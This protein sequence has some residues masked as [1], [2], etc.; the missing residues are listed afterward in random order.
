MLFSGVVP[1]V[2]RS[3]PS[4]FYRRELFASY[5]II[6][7][8]THLVIHL[9]SLIFCLCLIFI[10]IKL[11][12]SCTLGYGIPFPISFVTLFN[13]VMKLILTL[14]VLGTRSLFPLFD[15]PLLNKQFASPDPAY[16]IPSPRKFNLVILST[17]LRNR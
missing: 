7:C 2:P 11:V 3:T 1:I 15:L 10:V 8:D 16:G 5:L 6:S 14:L 9:L 13:S 4:L 17:H 12:F